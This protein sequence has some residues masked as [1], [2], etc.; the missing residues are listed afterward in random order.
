[1]SYR[2]TDQAAE[3]VQHIYTE[4][5]RLF[6]LEQAGRYHARL[7]QT[8]EVLA[9][10]PELARERLEITPAVRIH[11]CGAH[12]VIY[13]VDEVDVLIVRVRHGHEDWVNDL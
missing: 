13:I 5:S 9:H 8:F 6:G 11:R 10:F 2:L 1:M 3:D 12:V 4:G 7:R